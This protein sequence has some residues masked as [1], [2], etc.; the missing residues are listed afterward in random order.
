Q[1]VT[2]RLKATG[3]TGEVSRDFFEDL[4]GPDRRHGPKQREVEEQVT[5]AGPE[6]DVCIQDDPPRSP[7]H[8]SAGSSAACQWR[9][10]SSVALSRSFV[11]RT[12]RARC[13]PLYTSSAEGG[14]RRCVP[15]M[16]CGM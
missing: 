7:G 4:R 6:E 5:R 14:T 3:P 12:E 2:Q 10:R 15:T 13:F 16:R 8:V 9:S 1:F 11:G